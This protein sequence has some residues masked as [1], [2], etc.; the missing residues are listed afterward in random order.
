[1]PWINE[2]KCTGCEI[3]IDECP[4]DTIKMHE[5]V[6][7]IDM[8]NCIR[9]AV[10]HEVCPQDA[11]EHDSDK[12]DEW[13]KEKVDKAKWA[14]GECAK[15]FGDEEQATGCLKKLVRHYKRE[16]TIAEETIQLL[17]AIIEEREAK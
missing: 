4:V 9:C 8:E 11:V 1:M 16:I 13:I 10:C 15:Y 6:A 7:V 3:C 5:S 2:E 12:V 14:V 17:N